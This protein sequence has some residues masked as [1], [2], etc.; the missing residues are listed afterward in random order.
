MEPQN[1]KNMSSETNWKLRITVTG[2]MADFAF[3]TLYNGYLETVYTGYGS[4]EANFPTGLYKMILN[5][6]DAKV[7]QMIKLSNNQNI[8]V[9]TPQGISSSL[10]DGFRNTHKYYSEPARKFSNNPTASFEKQNENKTTNSSLFIFFRYASSENFI[11][12][13][14]DKESLGKNFK[15]LDKNRKLICELAGNYIV[16]DSNETGWL[17]FNAFLKPNNY[18]L[19]YSGSK[20]NKSDPSREIPV[21]ICEQWQTQVYMTFS[22]EPLFYSLLITLKKP[23][24]NFDSNYSESLYDIEGILQKFV[25]GI[26]FLPNSILRKLS[27]GKWENPMLGILAAHSY[28]KSGQKD[29]DNLFNTVVENLGGILGQNIPDIQVLI[30]MRDNHSGIV[31]SEIS[32]SEP[33]MLL[34]GMKTAIL[35]SS[36]ITSSTQIIAPFSI[37]DKITENLY[38]D[39]AWTS[40]KPITQIRAK[41]NTIVN[42]TKSIDLNPFKENKISDLLPGQTSLSEFNYGLSS[43]PKKMLDNIFGSKKQKEGFDIAKEI[44]GFQIQPESKLKNTTAAR[45]PSVLNSWVANSVLNIINDQNQEELNITDLASRLEITPTGITKTIKTIIDQEDKISMYI[46]NK[47]KSAENVAFNKQ[48]INKLKDLL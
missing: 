26:Y 29:N 48:N 31:S 42:E 47:D 2:P 37:A 13:N 44:S 30:M 11:A 45:K 23:D 34:T 7:E 33:C 46:N 32:I 3:I 10:A 16:E 14:L 1:T 22:N 38:P 9:Q 43:N 40:Y 18:Y 15:L 4:F 27:Y 39:M 36:K 35:N 21:R 24:I 17:A 25:N 41:S 6:N 20:I 5:I 8:S 28:Y 12:R 19:Y